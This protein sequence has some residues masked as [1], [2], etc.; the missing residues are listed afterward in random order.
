MFILETQWNWTVLLNFN[1]DYDVSLLA[2]QIIVSAWNE[3]V[4][5]KGHTLI[6]QFTWKKDYCS[7]LLLMAAISSGSTYPILS[8]GAPVYLVVRPLVEMQGGS[9]VPKGSCV[10]PPDFPRTCTPGIIR[11]LGCWKEGISSRAASP[12]ADSSLIDQEPA[13]GKTVRYF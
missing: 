7:S 3:N 12:F 6:T 13:K 5:K 10:L 2:T 9:V 8:K 1:Y 11:V 4:F